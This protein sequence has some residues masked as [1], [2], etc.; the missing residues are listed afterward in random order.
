LR[1]NG[2]KKGD[3]ICVFS[4]ITS[5]G[6]PTAIKKKVGA[7]GLNFLLDSYIDTFEDAVGEKGLVVMP[8]FT[9]SATRNQIFDVNNS[10]SEVGV[11]TEHFR[12]RPQAARS[13]HPIFSFA[14]RG[15]DAKKFL[16]LENFDC[17]GEKSILAKLYNLK[18]KYILFGVGMH[19]SATFILYSEQKNMVYYRYFKNFTGIVQ[20]GEKKFELAVKYFVRDLKYIYSWSELEEDA[21]ARRIIKNFKF[22]GG[23][24]L[25][26]DSRK[27]DELIGKKLKE[28]KNYLVT[29]LK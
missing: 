23:N 20:A 28:N 14:A 5:F 11:L 22:S 8:T 15:N 21:T 25:L 4:D 26:V 12:K 24:I 16:K 17:F 9:Y 19:E 1:N 29:Q 13:S 27:I 7:H 18:A 6:I 2:I 3:I 10:K